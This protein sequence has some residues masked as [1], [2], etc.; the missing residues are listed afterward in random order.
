MPK[1]VWRSTTVTHLRWIMFPKVLRLKPSVKSF[2]IFSLRSLQHIIYRVFFSDLADTHAHTSH[3]HIHIKRD[4]RITGT[5]AE[6][7]SYRECLAL[8]NIR[9]E[10]VIFNGVWKSPLL[11][12]DG[13]ETGGSCGKVMENKA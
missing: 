1:E 5:K 11:P 9:K 2:T 13:R 4:I 7:V 3:T 10:L 6:G 12:E 8:K